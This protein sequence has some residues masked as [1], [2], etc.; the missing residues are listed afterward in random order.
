MQ[1]PQLKSENPTSNID[2]VALESEKWIDSR[3]LRDLL[4][5]GKWLSGA[6]NFLESQAS[7]NVRKR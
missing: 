2:A 1:A 6:E 5:E 4:K 7:L 3:K